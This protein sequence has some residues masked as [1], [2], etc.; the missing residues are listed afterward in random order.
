MGREQSWSYAATNQRPPRLNSRNTMLPKS[1]RVRLGA[2]K[3][4]IRI[5]ALIQ[6]IR[7]V[8]VWQ[9]PIT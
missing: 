2:N 7:T 9:T 1:Q 3:R 4:R 8:M 6:P 5:I